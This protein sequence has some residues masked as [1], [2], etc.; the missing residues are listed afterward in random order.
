VLIAHKRPDLVDRL[1]CIAG[2]YNNNGWLPDVMEPT[3]EPPDFLI[4]SYAELSPDGA[5]HYR[6]VHQKLN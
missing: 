2:V 6:V 5:E 3:D 4:K 1:V